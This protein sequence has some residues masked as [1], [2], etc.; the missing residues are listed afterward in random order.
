MY[1][2]TGYI[3]I[4]IYILIYIYIYV[5]TYLSRVMHGASAQLLRSGQAEICVLNLPMHVEAEI[6]I[7]IHWCAN[8]K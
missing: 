2:Y 8:K 1:I 3:Y 4:Y 7:H 5:Y 6:C